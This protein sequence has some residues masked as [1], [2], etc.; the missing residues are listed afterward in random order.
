VECASGL[1]AAWRAR[2]LEAGSRPPYAESTG[3]GTAVV[4]RD[5][6]AYDARWSR[7]DRNG[8]MTFTTASGQPMT[9][10]RGPAWIVLA[11]RAK[12]GPGSAG[13]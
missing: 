1:E 3:S 4:L 11:A 12:P 10:A 9:F 2:F 8:G 5:G 13:H 6:R 7:P